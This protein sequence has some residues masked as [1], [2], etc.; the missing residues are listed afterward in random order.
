MLARPQGPARGHGLVHGAADHVDVGL[1]LPVLQHAAVG[2]AVHDDG[3]AALAAQ[4]RPALEVALED[5]VLDVADDGVVALQ[6]GH[7]G[8]HR[9]EGAVVVEVVVD[10]E[11]VGGH[12][13]GRLRLLEDIVVA[14]G[15]DLEDPVA[16]AGGPLDL[17]GEVLGRG[18][19]RPRRHRHP[20]P[21]L[22]PHQLPGR[23]LQAPAHQVVGRRVQPA[24]QV[25]V[26]EVEGVAA[27]QLLAH[28]GGRRVPGADA[29]VAP[30]HQPGVGGHAEQQPAVDAVEVDHAAGVAAGE[31]RIDG[32]DV[33]GGDAV[34]GHGISLS[35]AG[36]MT[37]GVKT[38]HL[39]RSC[40]PA[41]GDVVS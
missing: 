25:A 7:D 13:R 34:A 26:E 28:V 40:L 3:D 37:A 30:A 23:H 9:P 22:R 38:V 36:S 14:A 8:Q 31:P 33:D 18:G 39:N 4:G 20:V 16:L 32:D 17:G 19:S 2:R 27:D 5:R 12:L 41:G 10:A 21:P 6:L 11:A 1:V 29:M 15:V 24:G 35:V